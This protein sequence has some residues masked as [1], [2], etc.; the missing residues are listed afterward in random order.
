MV[1]MAQDFSTRMPLVNGQGNWGSPDD[2]K[3]FAAMRYTEAKLAKYSETLL[4]EIKQGTVDFRPNFDGT[5]KEPMFLPSQLPNILINGSEGI[6]V[7]I[8][9]V[10]PPHNIDEVILVGG[11]T[12]MP[13]VQEAL[14]NFFGK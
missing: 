2:P 3:S 6:A 12:R 8:S 13:K 10:I 11:Q 1:L 4:A 9:T 7:G 5:L 14:K